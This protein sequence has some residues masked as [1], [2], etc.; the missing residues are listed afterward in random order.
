MHLTVLAVP[1][2]PNVAVLQERLA[3]VLE[4]RRDVTVS[5]AVVADQQE[6]DG[7]GQAEGAPRCVSSARP[8][9]RH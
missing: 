4:D 9:V 5:H 6:G 8:S 1:G 2:C 7:D 3:H